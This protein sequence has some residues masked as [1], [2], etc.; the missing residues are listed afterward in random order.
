MFRKFISPGVRR[1]F[2]QLT[3]DNELDELHEGYFMTALRLLNTEMKELK[4]WAIFRE[5]T[6]TAKEKS[7][8]RKLV[9]E[10]GMFYSMV[11]MFALASATLD[12]DEDN[13]V[14]NMAL[15]QMRRFQTEL[16]FYFSPPEALKILKSPAAT[17]TTWQ[18]VIKFGD[19]LIH[20]G[21]TDYTTY[22]VSSYGHKKGDSKIWST[23]KALLPAVQ[24]IERTQTPEQAIKYFDKLF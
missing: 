8:L 9:A 4:D 6:L 10:I 7:N 18:R 1:R 13:W 24:G 21:D 11:G 12:D 23:F 16:G 15:Y 20:V 19:Q 2:G 5:N 3:I 22:Q 14:T 17:T